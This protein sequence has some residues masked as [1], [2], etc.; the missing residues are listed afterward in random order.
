MCTAFP[1]NNS[2]VAFGAPRPPPA[3]PASA[4]VMT[5][6]VA[7]AASLSLKSYDVKSTTSSFLL[8]Q[9]C[10]RASRA[11]RAPQ[12]T[13][14]MSMWVSVRVSVWV[15]VRVSMWVSVRVSVRVSVWASVKSEAK[16]HVS[17]GEPTPVSGCSVSISH[18]GRPF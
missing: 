18:H 17:V 15:S 1:T 5:A 7:L 10:I 16:V 8:L 11:N 14:G 2:F 9:I 13:W 4:A 6:V 12:V 3:P